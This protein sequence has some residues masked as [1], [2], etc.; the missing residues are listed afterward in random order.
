MLG[1]W[2]HSWHSPT[3]DDSYGSQTFTHRTFHFVGLNEAHD[4]TKCD[5]MEKHVPERNADD[6][7]KT[8]DH[9]NNFELLIFANILTALSLQ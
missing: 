7:R 4:L 2:E 1:N 5:E 9:D 3:N 6:V 8:S